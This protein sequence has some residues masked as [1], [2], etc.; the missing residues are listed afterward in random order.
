MT[1]EQIDALK[2]LREQGYAVIVWNREELRE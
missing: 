1:P 2:S